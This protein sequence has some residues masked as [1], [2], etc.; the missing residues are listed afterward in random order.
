MAIATNLVGSEKGLP[1]A[2]TV[3]LKSRVS[4]NSKRR[5]KVLTRVWPYGYEKT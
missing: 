3:G 4:V 2:D 5:R 1:K